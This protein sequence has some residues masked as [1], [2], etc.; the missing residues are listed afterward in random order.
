MDSSLGQRTVYAEIGFAI[1]KRYKLK[2]LLGKG[3]YGVVCSASDVYFPSD[4]PIAIKKVLHLFSP[5]DPIDKGL[6]GK[7]KNEIDVIKRA[8]KSSQNTLVKRAFREL[9]LMTHFRG[10]K[11]VRIAIFHMF[12]FYVVLTDG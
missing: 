4:R 3:T 5:I 9:R 12:F 10:H 7:S 8:E 2:K 1:D 6:T 11:N